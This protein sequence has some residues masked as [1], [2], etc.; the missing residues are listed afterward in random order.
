MLGRRHL[1]GSL[2]M[3]A[4]LPATLNAQPAGPYPSRPIRIVHG[5]GAGSNPDTIARVIAPSLMATLGQTV[6]V[7]PK[8]GAGERIAAQYLTTQP[9]DGYTLYLITGG[10]N[11]IS[12]TDP[13]VT[14]STLKDFTYISTITLFPF[15]LFV[16]E[17]SPLRNLKDLMAAARERPGKL[18]YGHAGTGNTLHLAVELLKSRTGIQMEPIA[19]KDQ[20]QL[21]T[22]VMNGRL[23]ASISTFTNFHGALVNKQARAIAVTSAERWPPNPDVPS[24]ADDVPGYE[25]VSWLGLA[26]PAGLPDD[27]AS[28]LADAVKTAVAVP[29]IRTRLTDMGN[30]ARAS[31]PAEFRARVVADYDKWKPLSK[32]VYP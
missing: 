26:A 18:N 17:K 12:A 11:V 4:A 8:P 5:Y 3:T 13:Q 32:I 19:Y 29:E 14:F 1:L 30:D 25:V 6:I 24:M 28:R 9:P 20:N 27:L 2:A 16:G 15:A 22:D 21:I 31:T 10:A 23:D 7:E